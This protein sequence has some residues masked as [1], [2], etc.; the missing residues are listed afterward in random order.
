[1]AAQGEN[2]QDASLNLTDREQ[3]KCPAKHPPGD[4]IYRDG[5]HSFF[6]VD[7]RK[8]PVYCQNLCLLAKLFLGSKTLYYDVEPFLFYVMT[9]N[10]RYGC[11]FVGY[12][13]KEK[14]PSS[15]NNVSCILV[16]PIYMRKGYGQYLIQFSYLL[17]RVEKKTGSPEKPLSDMGLVSYRKYWRIVLCEELLKQKGPISIAAISER[18]GMTADDIVSALEG[19]R[20]L[21][22]DPVTKS[23]A[24]RLDYNY[25]KEYLE[26]CNAN[27]NAKVNPDS[28]VWTPYV[29]GRLGD[30]YEDGPA[31]HT[32]QARE[33]VDE[34]AKASPEEG[35]QQMGKAAKNGLSH[36]DSPAPEEIVEPSTPALHGL[37]STNGDIPAPGTPLANGSHTPIFE[38]K[39]STIPPIPPT[40]YEVFPPIPGMTTGKRRPGRPFGSRRRAG[41]GTGTPQRT[42]NTPL[43]IQTAPVPRLQLSPRNHGAGKSS[44]VNGTLTPSGSMSMRRTRSRLG[45]SVVNGDGE[46]TLDGG[47]GAVRS[48]NGGHRRTRSYTASPKTNMTLSGNIKGKGKGKGKA[49]AIAA[50]EYLDEDADGE[51]EDLD[52]DAEGEMDVDGDEDVDAEGEEDDEGD[53]AMGGA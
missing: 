39:S 38:S 47:G 19:L 42:R 51:S 37:E 53:V 24:L 15:L 13:S 5:K 20:A 40:R 10:D 11:H 31:L 7:G 16:L 9:E 41:T 3:L 49:V 35:V 22:R 21:V 36:T 1:M 25:F 46:E 14:R 30:A 29:M 27:D 23:Y 12:F 44:P 2:T 33:E 6:E 26:K 8:N 43:S 4:E 17:T 52:V 50:D 18:T 45:E 34:E 48:L 28:L 32:I